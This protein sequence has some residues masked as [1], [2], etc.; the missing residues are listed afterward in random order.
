MLSLCKPRKT[1]QSDAIFYKD[2]TM[3]RRVTIKVSGRVQGVGYRASA[4]S[5]AASLNLTGWVRNLTDGRVEILA[6][7]DKASISALIDWCGQGP[8][9]AR[10]DGLDIMDGQPSGEFSGFSVKRDG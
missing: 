6:E 2:N 7:G 5:K 3:Q 9:W 8:R 4:Q 10:V 1:T